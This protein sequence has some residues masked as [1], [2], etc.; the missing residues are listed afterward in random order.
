MT[1]DRKILRKKC[2]PAYGSSYWRI[3]MNQENCNQFTYPGT[4]TAIK[5]RRLERMC[6]L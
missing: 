5:V 4:V 2:G 3:N 1:W 6:E